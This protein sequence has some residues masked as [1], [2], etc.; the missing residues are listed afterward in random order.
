[1]CYLHHVC[2]FGRI[3]PSLKLFLGRMGSFWT[4]VIIDPKSITVR[5]RAAEI[6]PCRENVS[7]LKPCAQSESIELSHN[8]QIWPSWHLIQMPQTILKE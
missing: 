6:K 7:I 3:A 8:T 5:E 1:M 2:N 4:C